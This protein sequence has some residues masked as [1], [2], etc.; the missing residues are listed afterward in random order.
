LSNAP[1]VPWL[2]LLFTKRQDIEGKREG[3]FCSGFY[4]LKQ[5]P[6]KFGLPP[7][8]KIIFHLNWGVL[9]CCHEEPSSKNE[10][11]FL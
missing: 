6:E 11:S 3:D 4:H 5:G 8:L 2:I 9:I 1:T 7:R 10:H